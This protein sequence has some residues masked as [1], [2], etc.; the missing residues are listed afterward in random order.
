MNLIQ[1]IFAAFFL[2]MVMS[3]P[4]TAAGNKCSYSKSL[5]HKGT[6]FD[7]VSRPAHGCGVQVVT[8]TVQRRGKII[9]TVKADVDYLTQSAKV[10]DLTGDG[11]PELAVISRAS[12][13]TATET[14]DVYWLNGTT[15]RGIT[16]PDLDEKSGYRGGDRYN[17]EGRLI[18]RT[19]PVYRYDDSIEKPT[20]GTR[21]LKYDF[22]DGAF[23]L[24]VQTERASNLYSDSSAQSTAFGTPE[25]PA[26][27]KPARSN[28]AGLAITEITAGESGIEIRANGAM[29]K[30]KTMRLDKPERIAIDIPDADSSLAGKKVAI[31]RF[32]ISK[33]RV[34][35]NKGFLRVV[36][37]TTLTAFPKYEVKPSDSGLRIVFTQ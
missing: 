22:K 11:R 24:Y 16:V 2:L 12:G 19:I 29:G 27:S 31:N 18:V 26:E 36:L 25:T 7:I 35:R 5:H 33:A 17:I 6:V 30:Y 1:C 10:V 3:R 32:G 20:G 34:G 4:V 15:L 14:M 21:S 37:D 13:A 23:S 9:A 8:V 28:S